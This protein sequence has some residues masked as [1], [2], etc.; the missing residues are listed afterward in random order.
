MVGLD[1]GVENFNFALNDFFVAEVCQASTRL[2]QPAAGATAAP[3][4]TAA[5]TSC[6]M[7]QSCEANESTFDLCNF[8]RFA[9]C[10]EKYG[11]LLQIFSWS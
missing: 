9:R 1:L 4:P 5:A 11:F 6:A 7:P 8:Q 2:S 10:Y 3:T